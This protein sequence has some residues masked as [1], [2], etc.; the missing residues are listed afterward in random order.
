MHSLLPGLMHYHHHQLF[1]DADIQHSRYNWGS[2]KHHSRRGQR[3]SWRTSFTLG[4]NEGGFGDKSKEIY[5]SVIGSGYV[6]LGKR[7]SVQQRRVHCQKPVLLTEAPLNPKAN[8]EKM[9]QIMFETFNTPTFYVAIQAVLSLYVSG[10][11]TGIVLDSGD[12]KFCYVAL[13][14]EQEMRTAAQSS[15]LEKSYELP[16]GQVITI[17]NERFHAP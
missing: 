8:R 3:N 12:V 6:A 9:T 14:F 4:N 13:D 10:H 2:L 1:Y 11:T 17:G 15:A 5:G 16:D 7:L